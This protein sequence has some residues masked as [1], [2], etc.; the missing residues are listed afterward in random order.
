MTRDDYAQMEAKLMAE[1]VQRRK[2]GGYNPDAPAI[3]FICEV[4]FELVREMSAQAPKT[5]K[6][7]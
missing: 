3:L 2:L 7:G 6:R 4:L 1:I 5:P